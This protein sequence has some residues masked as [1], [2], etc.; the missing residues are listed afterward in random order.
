MAKNK[1]NKF[2]GAVA[3]GAA[4]LAVPGCTDTW[5]DHYN[6]GDLQTQATQSLWEIIDQKEELSYFKAIAQNAK[7]WKDEKHEVKEYSFED[8]LKSGQINTVWAPT[9]DA[10]KDDY[11]KWM[12][13]C[14]T[15]GYSVMQQFMSNHIAMFRYNYSD[16]KI[17]TIK[18][19]NG[20][21]QVFNKKDCTFQGIPVV[22]KNIPAVNGMLHTISGV[23][24][25]HYNFYE[26]FKFGKDSEKFTEFLL[27]RDTVYFNEGLSIEGMPDKDGNPTYNDSVYVT[28]NRLFNYSW[29][30]ATNPDD[31]D[32][33]EKGINFDISRED[34]SIVMCIP[35][36]EAWDEAVK[37]LKPFYKYPVK[38]VD[39]QKRTKKTLAAADYDRNI[40]DT[41]A[42]SE[43]SL[44]Q[45]L[46]APAVFNIHEQPKKDG[47]VW[48]IEKFLRELES[49]NTPDYMLNTRWD[50]IFNTADSEEINTWNIKELF[51]GEKKV[52]SNGIAFI[53]D[54][55]AFPASYYKPDVEVDVNG[56]FFLSNNTDFYTAGTSSKLVSFNNAIYDD[57]ANRFGKV[58]NNNFYYFENANG[59]AFT[60]EIPLRGNVSDAYVPNAEVRSGK[61][62]I[63]AV[64]VPLFY[65]DIANYGM[66]SLYYAS[67]DEILEYVKKNNYYTR[68]QALVRCND[69]DKEVTWKAY[70]PSGTKTD[71]S[72]NTFQVEG[73]DACN[74][75]SVKLIEGFEFPTSYVGLRKSFP[76]LQIKS[77]GK[78]AT[79]TAPGYSFDL[80]IDRIILKSQETG[81]QIAIK[82]EN[83]K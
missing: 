64:I 4:I 30:P 73:M 82:P 78:A 48:E 1:I 29:L 20:K 56:S 11:E 33:A 69:V 31:I 71:A 66:D 43:M 15:D 9:N 8:V 72:G 42:L 38:Y 51:T 41:A 58:Y 68:F 55:W 6:G 39:M 52:M 34:S 26:Q 23:V 47:E 18:T 75:T 40:A 53:N 81:E 76:T 59:K 83:L 10:L 2:L 19:I 63:Y 54:K 32:I 49:G 45:D 46:I 12:E 21:N 74:V 60:V 24:P 36:D 25:F 57:V 37:M 28:S 62:D 67:D 44:V 27:S 77:A 5:D 80:C 79:K 50:T 22:E 17:D 35:S 16:N 61:Y 3:V 13:M 7:Y 65:K 70:H 14:E